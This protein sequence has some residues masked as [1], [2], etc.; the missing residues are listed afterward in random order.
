MVLATCEIALVAFH[1][2]THVAVFCSD[3]LERC[4]RRG[5]IACFKV[6][7]ISS[8]SVKGGAA[9]KDLWLAQTAYL[10]VCRPGNE[11]AVKAY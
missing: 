6:D 9:H 3:F 7:I 11:A 4:S 8:N 1:I 2:C 5:F 10:Q